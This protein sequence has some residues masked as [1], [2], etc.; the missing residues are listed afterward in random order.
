MILSCAI[1]AVFLFVESS[2]PLTGAV[3][4][5]LIAACVDVVTGVAMVFPQL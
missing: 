3:V 2:A 1:S 5:A 4:A